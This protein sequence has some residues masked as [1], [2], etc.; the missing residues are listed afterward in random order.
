MTVAGRPQTQ[1][2]PGARVRPAEPQDAASAR[3]GQEDPGD[4][5][6]TLLQVAR[7]TGRNVELLRRW[8]VAGRIPAR[9]MGRDWFIRRREL[10]RIERMPRRR[11]APAGGRLDDRGILNDS[12]NREID[13]CLEPDETVRVVLLGMDGSALIAS[14]RK[15]LMAR[16]GVLVTSPAGGVPAAWPLDQ[17]RRVQLDAGSAS[18]ALVLTPRDPDDRAV[19]I[20]LA[21][22]HLGRAA[23]AADAL[24]ALLA[25]GGRH[26]GD[27]TS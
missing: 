13:R 27:P 18:G 11:I 3:P 14:D 9:R 20:L 4:G 17:L 19:V 23:A 24:R 21:R 8:C 6:L 22:Q 10:E 15:V 26:R 5:L 2:L 16:D 7:E 12:L 1:D 25:D